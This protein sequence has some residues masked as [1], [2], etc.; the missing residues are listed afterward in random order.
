MTVGER[1]RAKREEL[2]LSQSELARKVGLTRQGLCKYEL[3][4]ADPRLFNAMCIAEALGVS[5]DYLAGRCE[6]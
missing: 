2:G 4:R 5:L 3:D 6:A 1:I